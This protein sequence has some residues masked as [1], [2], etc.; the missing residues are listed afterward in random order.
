MSSI[1]RRHS[2]A[3]HAGPN[4]Y[5]CIRSRY[6]FGISRKSRSAVSP[7]AVIA[8]NANA[9]EVA[10][11]RLRVGI[12]E[13]AYHRPPPTPQLARCENGGEADSRPLCNQ[14]DTLAHVPAVG[15]VAEAGS[16]GDMRS[17]S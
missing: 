5:Q 1:S 3:V 14:G 8:R 17:V 15:W 4:T 12:R 11:N 7:A 13:R 6:S 16:A 9:A 2:S 10:K